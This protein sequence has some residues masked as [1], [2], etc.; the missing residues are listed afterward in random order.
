MAVS[1]ERQTCSVR[2]QDPPAPSPAAFELAEQ[3]GP[4][5]NLLRVATRGISSPSFFGP[6]PKP[7]NT[8]LACHRY[9][10]YLVAL[11]P[12]TVTTSSLHTSGQQ[13][14]LSGGIHAPWF[15]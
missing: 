9:M 13:L 8:R 2:L 10:P 14:P 7:G 1:C 5:A 12:E 3:T 11:L 15:A 6:P 4:S